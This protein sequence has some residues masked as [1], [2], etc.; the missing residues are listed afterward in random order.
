VRTAARYRAGHRCR[1]QG[2]RLASNARTT[3]HP[4]PML[5]AVPSD[6]PSLRAAPRT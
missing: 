2:A 4:C 5:L 3:L 6:A 1:V